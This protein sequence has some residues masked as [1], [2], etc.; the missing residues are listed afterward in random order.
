MAPGVSMFAGRHKFPQTFDVAGAMIKIS[1]NGSIVETFATG[2]RNPDG[3]FWG[4]E[5]ELF[6]MDDQGTYRPSSALIHVRQGGYYGQLSFKKQKQQ[7]ISAG[8][9]WLPHYIISRSP[10][11]PLYVK[12]GPF[13]GQVFYAD[14]T[15]INGISRIFL[16][17]VD[18]LYQGNP[19]HFT[20]GMRAGTHNVVRGPDG[21][22][23]V[24]CLGNGNT[25]GWG[26]RK[27]LTWGMHRLRPNGKTAFEMLAVR[28]MGPKSYE[29]E[30]TKPVG[31]P[32]SPSNFSVI[33]FTHVPQAGYGAGNEVDKS[34][35]TVS[36]VSLSADNM[37]A[38]LVFPSNKLK[39]GYMTHFRLKDVQSANGEKPWAKETWYQ[40][41]K[42][43][44]AEVPGCLDTLYEEYNAS[45]DY[46]PGSGI[47]CRTLKTGSAR[48]ISGAR[49][50][51]GMRIVRM[52]SNFLINVPFK[53]PYKI[54]VSD[55]K[56]AVI[57]TF[58]HDKPGKY[59]LPVD[60]VLPGI[61][62]VRVTAKNFHHSERIVAF[63]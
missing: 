63:E 27:G 57:K 39:E 26:W 49:N 44:P 4:P 59:F 12:Q 34:R 16:E 2:L 50:S 25:G 9:T 11:G 38:T 35:L 51:G 52:Q 6:T 10:H 40:L 15:L 47:E 19:H 62:M 41:N 43:G 21:N 28:S 45:A 30:F 14:C 31:A 20:A 53:I 23:Y 3:L 5:G 8:I 36:S 1:K 7:P 46:D 17:R 13:R 48:K 22:L 42:F 32:L 55:M 29:I 18:G 33:Q 61:Y 37:R 54:S 56:G 60:A 58:S 24:G